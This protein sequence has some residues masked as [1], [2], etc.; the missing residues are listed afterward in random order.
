MEIVVAAEPVL[1]ALAG[2]V[3]DFLRTGFH[4][5]HVDARRTI[6]DDAEIMGAEGH[7]ARARRGDQG[8]GGLAAGIDAGAAEELAL[9]QGYLPARGGE[10]SGE[11]RASLAGADDDGVIAF[12]ARPHGASRVLIR[13]WAGAAAAGRSAQTMRKPPMTATASSISAAGRSRPKLAD[14]RPR[15]AAPP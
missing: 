11:R 10:T 7:V 12:H 1:D 9:D 2:V 4:L 14:R 8:L 15:T 5:A 13:A 6:E 3:D